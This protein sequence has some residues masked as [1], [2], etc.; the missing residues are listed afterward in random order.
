M[1]SELLFGERFQIIDTAASWLKIE[2]LFD[3][4]IGWIDSL[5]LGYEGWD[6][7]S[8]GVIT[9]NRLECSKEDNTPLTLSPGSE[10]F[11]LNDSFYG[12][13]IGGKQFTVR[14][15]QASLLTPHSSM[16]ETAL[17]FLNVPYLWG[18]RTDGGIDCSGLVQVVCKIHGI[19]LPRDA[20]RQAEMGTIVSFFGEARP[21]DLIFFSGE[22]ERISHTGIF[23]GSGK[24]IHSSGAVRIDR[25]DHQGIW[26][27]DAGRYTHRLRVIK[28]VL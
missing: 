27:D 3:Q 25:V 19:K 2:T 4:Y 14:D 26:C 20:A 24:I 23:M 12:F 11:G 15:T 28:R 8:Q 10:I 17:Q 5:H 7:G 9:G 22:T 21:G 18:G 6:E 1:V 16:T 13:A